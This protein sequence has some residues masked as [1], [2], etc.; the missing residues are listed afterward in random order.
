MNQN[1]YLALLHLLPGMT[2]KRL[3][4]LFEKYYGDWK[5]VWDICDAKIL[6]EL[7]IKDD[8]I[9]K[10]LHKKETISPAVMEK[11]L[12]EKEIF[13]ITQKDPLYPGIFLETNPAPFLLYL[14]G[15]KKL[16]ESSNNFAIVGTRKMTVYGTQIID[17]FL[18]DLLNVDL[19]I[20]SGLAFGVDSYVHKKVLEYGGKTIAV[21]G[22]GIDIVYPS[23]NKKLVEELLKKD[24]LLLSEF[25]LGKMPE[26]FHFPMRNRII[27]ALSK[28]VLVVEAGEKSGACI[29]A[30]IAVDLGKE[31]FAVPG[32]IFA[33][34]A[35]GTNDLL[36]KGTAHPVTDAKSILEILGFSVPQSPKESTM[37][38]PFLELFSFLPEEH[39]NIFSRYEGT[40]QEFQMELTMM[41]L[42]G[43]IRKVEG[44][45]W[46]RT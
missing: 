40:V 29:T 38:E 11:Y 4:R 20:V 34:Y 5:E 41:E 18:P 43:K 45:K 46:V 26:P 12:K 9:E 3:Q 21:I 31:V 36:K 22:S 1:P 15:N 42:S 27:A 19:S 39:E 10:A 2:H 32:N 30:E 25:P 23:S 14:R 13:L 24:G 6:K 33:P 17:A 7:G 8:Q 28:G 35:V 37:I 44:T 16:L